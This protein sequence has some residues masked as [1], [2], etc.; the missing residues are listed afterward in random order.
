MRKRTLKMVV[1]LVVCVSSCDDGSYLP[2]DTGDRTCLS[3][4]PARQ[5]GTQFT[6]L[7][8]LEDW[9]GQSGWWYTETVY[10]SALRSEPT[11]SRTDDRLMI[12]LTPCHYASKPASRCWCAVC[13]R[14]C[15]VVCVRVCTVTCGCLCQNSRTL[16]QVDF[17]A[18]IS[19]RWRN[20]NW[21]S[22]I[23]DDHQRLMSRSLSSISS[24]LFLW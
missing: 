19:K 2:P 13:V 4:M 12:S 11:G 21:Q 6:Y 15:T 5:A 22:I 1:V 20:R 3:L 16:M 14:V 8:G 18:C 10:L 24:C 9:V 17:I 7:E 23:H